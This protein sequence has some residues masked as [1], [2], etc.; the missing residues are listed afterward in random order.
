MKFQAILSSLYQK[1]Q[2]LSMNGLLEPNNE[3]YLQLSNEKIG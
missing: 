2:S 3:E 1:K